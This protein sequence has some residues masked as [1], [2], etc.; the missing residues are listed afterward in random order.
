LIVKTMVTPADGHGERD[1]AVVMV[2]GVH[3]EQ[4]I[5]VAADKGYDTRDLI[6]GLR[7]MHVRRTS[8]NTTPVAAARS[9]RERRGTPATP[10]VN[11]NGS[12]PNKVSAG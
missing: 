8:H 6:A 7:A 1:A 11:R 10:S 4:R 2:A 9:T 5:T 3:G 12:S